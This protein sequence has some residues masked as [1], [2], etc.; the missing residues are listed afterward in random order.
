MDT[1]GASVTGSADMEK[2]VA[3]TGVP[4]WAAQCSGATMHAKKL[5]LSRVKLRM[6]SV[7]RRRYAPPS[8]ARNSDYLWLAAMAASFSSA[9]TC[10]S[11]FFAF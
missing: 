4:V 5:R 9:F 8:M 3:G 7:R 2:K 10:S 1:L 11:K 6:G